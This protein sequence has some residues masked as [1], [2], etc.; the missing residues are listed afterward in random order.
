[1]LAGALEI[2]VRADISQIKADLAA[3]KAT[4]ATTIDSM[5]GGL[6]KLR[7]G[8]ALV[9]VGL[10]FNE[11]I[12]LVDAYTKFTVQLRLASATNQIFAQSMED[13]RRI[14]TAAQTDLSNVGILYSRIQRSTEQL[15]LSQKKVAEIT[16]V[17]SLALRSSGATAVEAAS[18]TLQLS[19]SFASGV[20][21]GEEFN[22]VNEA[23][24]RLMKAL[25]DGMGLPVAALKTMAS[26][27]KL[28]SDIL[29]EALPKSLA[30]LR[31]EAA[32]VQTIGGSFT[33]LKNA[34]MEYVGA[35]AQSH[36]TTRVF[37]G[38]LEGLAKNLD[39]VVGLLGTMV[40]VKV[41]TWISAQ[42]AS[43]VSAAAAYKAYAAAYVTQAEAA[44]A[45][46][47]GQLAVAEATTVER[48]AILASAQ[49][50]V[51]KTA[52][53]IAFIEADRAKALSLLQSSRMTMEA[54]AA[55]GALSFALRENTTAT[56]ANGA[57][58]A[59]LAALGKLQNA[60]RAQMA[61]A[62]TA[63]A[64]ATAGLAAAQT[65]AAGASATLATATA[66]VAAA[67]RAGTAAVGLGSAALTALG[68]PVG[69]VV[70][71]LGLAATAWA[72]FGRSAKDANQDALTST[73]SASDETIENLDKQIEK[74]K[75]RNAAAK[76][77]VP[78]FVKEALSDEQ[79]EALASIQ[80]EMN[81]LTEKSMT[82]QVAAT[83][84]LQEGYKNILDEEELR[85]KA[86]T[87][88]AGLTQHEATALSNMLG[89]QIESTQVMEQQ[90]GL[91]SAEAL[92]LEQLKAKYEKIMDQVATLL[93]LN[94]E[95][96]DLNREQLTKTWL[97]KYANDAEK[98]GMKLAEASKAF[99]GLIPPEVEK[100][101]REMFRDKQAEANMKAR[102]DLA[103]TLEKTTIESLRNAA[104]QEQEILDFNQ[105]EGLVSIESYYRAR[106]E[107]IA[108]ETSA[109]ITVIENAIK[110]LKAEQ[111]PDMTEADRL[112][113]YKDIIEQEAKLDMVV[114]N[115]SH[116]R[117]MAYKEETKAVQDLEI[118]IGKALADSYAIL[119]KISDEAGS[120]V[121]AAGEQS[122][123]VRQ[124][125]EFEISLIG[126]T[127]HEQERLT[128]LRAI[129]L[130]VRRDILALPMD[131]E[132][133]LLVASLEARDKLI[134][135]ADEDK[136]AWEANFERKK[137]LEVEDQLRV[138]GLRE[139]WSTVDAAAFSV[140]D[141]IF[142]KGENT[143]K[144]LGASLKKWIIKALYELTIQKWGMQLF[145]DLT[146]ATF[147]P[148]GMIQGVS[149]TA[150][151]INQVS[152]LFSTASGA[153]SMVS[154][155]NS[156][157]NWLG[158]SSAAAAGTNA[159]P[160]GYGATAGAFGTA[161]MGSGAGFVGGGAV[162]TA[163]GLAAGEGSAL[164]AGAG[165]E[166][167]GVAAGAAWVPVV[168][169]VVA[170]AAL[171]YALLAASDEPSP[172]RGGLAF[173]SPFE[174]NTPPTSTK[175]GDIGFGD[176]QTQQFSGKVGKLM[177]DAI[178]SLLDI[179]ASQ[180]SPEAIE[181]V[182]QTLHDTVL[183]SFEGTFTTE[184][185]VNT[186]GPAMAKQLLDPALR[187]IDPYAAELVQA[188]DGP[189]D[190]F[191]A[192]AAD[193]LAATSTLKD[194]AAQLKVV[195]GETL[196]LTMLDSVRKEGETFGD[197]LKRIGMVFETTT[198]IAQ[199]M[200][201]DQT[202]MWG[203]IG[204]ASA[205]AR[206]EFVDSA[207]GI[208]SLSATV[209]AYYAATTTDVERHRDALDA[210][211]AQFDALGVQMPDNL[212][213]LEDM[214]K[215]QDLSTES[216]RALWLALMRLAPGFK[217]VT[218]QVEGLDGKMH[219][220]TEV[221]DQ[222]GALTDRR[223][224]AFGTKTQQQVERE[225]ELATA[226]DETS[227][228][229]LR[230][231]HAREDYNAGAAAKLELETQL[232]ALTHSEA[233]VLERSREMRIAELEMKEQELGLA[234]GTLVAIQLQIDAQTDLNRARDKEKEQLKTTSELQGRLGVLRGDFTQKELD[235]A[236]EWQAAASSTDKSLLT[237]IYL[238]EDLADAVDKAGI[239]LDEITDII[240][241]G[242]LG[243]LEEGESPGKLIADM[244]IGGIKKTMADQAAQ[245]IT[246]IIYENLIKPI[247][248]QI[249][250]GSIDIAAIHAIIT[251]ADIDAMIAQ[252]TTIVTNLTAIFNDPTFQAAL[253]SFSNSIIGIGSVISGVGATL[254]GPGP[255]TGYD[256]GP[257]PGPG[258]LLIS[259]VWV[260]DP[261]YVPPQ[262]D[263]LKQRLEMLARLYELTGDK[264]AA[265]AILEQQHA[266]A[267]SELDPSLRDLQVQ[268]WAAEKAAAAAAKTLE[269]KNAKESL[270]IQLY[271]AQG[272][273]QAAVEIERQQI[274][275]QIN[276]QWGEGSDRAKELIALYQELWAV[277]GQA[278][279]S[280]SQ[281]IKQLQD[282]LRAM[283][284]DSTLSPLTSSQRLDAAQSQ[285]VEDLLKAQQ[286]DADARNRFTQDAE[287]YLRE[288]LA[289]YG[290][291]SN[292]YNAIWMAIQEQTQGLIAAG[293][294]P[295][296]TTLTD[297]D[298]TISTGQQTAK[299]QA[300]M[301][302]AKVQA[303]T[304]EVAALRREQAEASSEAQ[305]ALDEQ[306]DILR[307]QPREIATE[308]SNTLGGTPLA[309]R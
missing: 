12:A 155:A 222:H 146:G 284:L 226:I 156:A 163:G 119:A 133:N 268:L 215:A 103:K 123:S 171:A 307:D 247:M 11:I 90:A 239:S 145:A 297:L 70:T 75:Q 224:I 50:E 178:G 55:A 213:Q 216:G 45:V 220:R 165:A 57:A 267:L 71:V 117:T 56:L 86:A 234:P 95:N 188:F 116:R 176:A 265:A 26:Q 154:G 258:Y 132:G 202:K 29:A 121:A 111:T 81:A 46:A 232:F 243:Q 87:R 152:S 47:A 298:T 59:E 42:I 173:N 274:L 196:T 48:A 14:A 218:D 255:G 281:W 257:S 263:T 183:L 300:D 98:L 20:F 190:K 283:K 118:A 259:G 193:V 223:D 105:R 157:W 277:Q 275:D 271:R 83:A 191:I 7:A 125:M 106:H 30:E 85:A 151:A 172:A 122:R 303:L 139:A 2:Q 269:F 49:A 39:L 73:K 33:L 208:E 144:Q 129:D 101:L 279:E 289:M 210:M 60:Q 159:A 44:A 301:L 120:V 248:T 3:V 18:A 126:K 217:E 34:V 76:A 80:G 304:D 252:A 25:A 78:L 15:G 102:I 74:L 170:I 201:E 22:A 124:Q 24:P 254:P 207:G 185:F 93:D 143:W 280:G 306:N 19:Q 253:N 290:R 230:E 206:Q 32:Q 138:E 69:A 246:D 96:A 272:N 4:F 204:F 162:G 109:E 180:L 127:A 209:S 82:A 261:N 112:K 31:K 205:A 293:L 256:P 305:T 115:A 249:I 54:T 110:A 35:S 97:E 37:A 88:A 203:S 92:R 158:G 164:A 53:T 219:S 174:D 72:V 175:F 260:L 278:G 153:N 200:G 177:T 10:G 286:G 91:T 9:G 52:A 231:I 68:G 189:F 299:E 242:L 221:E 58:M 66:G 150:N 148:G 40:A 79:R 287:A 100:R 294:A 8:L 13:V 167:A 214:V 292:D 6:S 1:M 295:T 198:R 241:K 282:W 16:E 104:R 228:A 28:T 244:V 161:T 142:E 235:R 130:Q 238:E 285:Y 296:E 43:L 229:L 94:R 107:I 212:E 169:W 51:A 36:G 186:F 168:G 195:F 108:R 38:A 182:K 61:A 276:K 64:A 147:G 65:A 140:F 251:Q 137:K 291:G 288:A 84:K 236:K 27:G 141:A 266:L 149:G 240:S 89:V 5:E 166:A 114:T 270:L 233:E 128:G 131:G 62:T 197:A 135:K 77:Q 225:H 67:Q 199:I 113:N 21:R 309:T 273:E 17:V 250:S 23:A 245:Q 99:H 134:K 227:L 41:A 237:Q 187:A 194:H 211:R 179:A 308:F 63:Q 262:A 264:A 302:I 136:L 181:S 192:F 160:I 184:D